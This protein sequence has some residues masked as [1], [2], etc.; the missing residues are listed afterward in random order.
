MN[1]TDDEDN[2]I[3]LYAREH[4]VAHQLLSQE[5]P[6]N[7]SLLYAWWM[8]SHCLGTKEQERYTLTPEEYESVRISFSKMRSKQSCGEKNNFYGKHHTEE[9]KKKM[10]ERHYDSSGENNSMYGKGYL[11]AGEKNRMYGVHRYGTA[12]PNYGHKWTDEQKKKA[13]ERQKGHGMTPVYCIELDEAFAGITE[14]SNKY[15]ISA[16][17]IGNCINGRQKSAGKHPDTGE[18]LHWRKMENNDVK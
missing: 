16:S 13:S 9:T 6:D 12:A 4:F 11:I 15:N 10:R 8:M 3:D 7:H 2:L 17:S 14:A 1:G 5:N 18:K